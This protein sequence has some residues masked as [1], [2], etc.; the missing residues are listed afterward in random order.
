M[1]LF[2]EIEETEYK[3]D[4]EKNRLFETHQRSSKSFWD[5][6]KFLI[7]IILLVIGAVAA[8]VYFSLPRVGDKVHPPQDLYDAVYDD[9]LT[10]EKRTATDMIFYYCGDSYT[11]DVT[12]ES[13]GVASTKAEDKTTEFEVVAQKAEDGGWKITAAPLGPE[14]QNHLIPCRRFAVD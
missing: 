11:V 6:E 10:R 13:K 3:D 1:G 8:A 14:F 12:V 4:I 7:P 5:Y 9:M 2:D